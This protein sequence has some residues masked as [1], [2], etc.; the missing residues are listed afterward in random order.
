MVTERKE[1]DLTIG[2]FAGFLNNDG[3]LLIQRRKESG[4][5]I[6]GQNFLG[7]YELPGGGLNR[8]EK[9][10]LGR[11]ALLSIPMSGSLAAID[12]LVLSGISLPNCWQVLANA[13]SREVKEEEGLSINWG[14]I[15]SP[16]TYRAILV[17]KKI[18]KID[19]ALV[20]PIF[21]REWSGAPT[22]E[23]E[24]ADAER[25]RE[26]SQ[27]PKGEQ[28]LSGWGKRMCQ[29]MLWCLRFSC[30]REIGDTA[31]GYLLE[32]HKEKGYD[33]RTNQTVSVI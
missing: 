21:P 12:F 4:S 11:A 8:E 5:V 30:Y 14:I 22:G 3:R 10:R 24:W 16:F 13:L 31:R 25:V 28:I 18:A 20:M 27:K 9:E 1:F 26:L 23:F 33:M 17:Q 15:L 29:M 19:I 32:I 7:D 2:V 6:P